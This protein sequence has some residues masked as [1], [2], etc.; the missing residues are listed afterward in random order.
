MSQSVRG[1][2]WAV[3]D[4]VP[5]GDLGGGDYPRLIA[6]LLALRGVRA[7]ADARGFFFGG[8]APSDPRDL[9]GVERAVRRILAAIAAQERIAVY[10]D[11]DV[12]GVSATA[13]LS[14]GVRALGGDVITHIPDRFADGYGLTR[15]GLR[16]VR[17]RGAE[18]VITVDCGINANPEVEYAAEIGLGVVVLD[19]HAP[20]PVLP[21]AEAIVDPK[22]GDGPPEY[23]GLASCGLALTVLRALYDAAG[24]SLDEDQYVGLAALGTVADMVPLV[25][26]NRRLVREGL[27]ALERSRR[28]GIRALIASAGLETE[29]LGAEHIAFRL[30]PRLNAAG[31]LAHASLA[32]ELLTTDDDARAAGLAQTLNDLNTRRQR[33]TDEAVELARRLAAAECT[34]SPLIMVGHERLAQGIVGLVAGKLAEESYRP[35]IVYEW[36][37]DMCR[38]SVRSIR[39]LDAVRCLAQGGDLLERWGGH[40]QAGGFTVRTAHLPR[41]KDQLCAWVGNELAGADLRPTFTADLDVPLSQI[42][43]PEVR[44]LP[45]FEPCGQDSPT[46]VFISRRVPVMKSWTVGA[47][48]R[49]LRLKLREGVATWDAVAFD[50]GHALPRPG[51]RVDLLY[52]LAPDRRGFGMELRLLDFAPAH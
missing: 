46:P 12:D 10:G 49:H 42:R 43:G 38:G 29:R 23:D 5:L 51:S 27:K 7:R 24:S 13:I 40:S 2:R 44:W 16:A 28:P 33:M 31:R 9:P 3:R 14:D 11:Y 17:D 25:G 18:L 6:H 32:L 20:P 48:G 19:H 35:S 8:P 37:A 34:G 39:E 47:D 4:P 22:L 26:E 52:T 1:R 45:Y 41:L 30:A 50:M 21:D 36:R 15:A